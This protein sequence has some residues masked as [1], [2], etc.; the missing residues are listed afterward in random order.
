LAGDPL[1]VFFERNDERIAQVVARFG[2]YQPQAVDREKIRIWLRQFDP[3]DFDLALR[4]LESVQFYDLPRLLNLLSTLHRAIKANAAAEGFR[5]NEEF[6][7]L[8]IGRTGD[9]GYEIVNRYR[10][11]NRLGHTRV[12][13][14]QV[15]E[16]QQIL[17]EAATS[18]GRKVLVF[19]DDFVGTGKQVCDF[20]EDVL[21]Q[22]VHPSIPM[23]LGT[24]LACEAGI[25][26][27]QQRTPLRVIAVHIVQRRHLFSQTDLFTPAEKDRLTNVY[28]QIGNPTLGVGGLGVLV[29]FAH[30]CP[31]N[32]LGVLRG[33][34]RQRRW[35]GIL[36]RFDDI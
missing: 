21:S 7:F 27:I 15:V 8:P 5:R 20:W 33:S 14:A 30:G 26:V 6:V 34:K 3:Q 29:A 9:S 31:N 17:Y 16:L 1:S 36:P 25:E 19:L 23:Y 35:R 12:T 10:N 28:G 18:D 22:H 2:S 24:A 4:I 32:T 13:F 11:I